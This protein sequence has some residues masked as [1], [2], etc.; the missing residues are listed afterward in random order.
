MSKPVKYFMIAAACIGIVIIAGVVAV[1]MLVDIERY[2]PKIEQLVTEKTGYPLTLGGE[3]SLSIFPWVGLSFTELQLDNP[4]G[5]VDKK[6]VRIDSFQARLKVL[7]LL[8]RNVE[9]SSFVVKQP[10]IFLEKNA[11]GIWNWQKLS[12]STKTP[13]ATP[14]AA[15]PASAP[16]PVAGESGKQPA[17]K[18]L[19]QDGFVLQ[20]LVVGEFAITDGRIH[21]N[22]LQN[23]VKHEV[24]DFNLQL[25]DVSL[26]TPIKITMSSHLD[27]KPL[28]LKGWAGPVGSDPGVGRL[29]LDLVVEAL[30]TMTVETSGYVDDL[31]G[32]KKYNLDVN[33]PTFSLKKLYSVLDMPFPVATAD[34]KVLDEISLQTTVAGDA[35][36]VALSGAKII[37][38]DSTITLD[39]TAKDFSRPDLAMNLVVDAID[40]DR[41]LPP[42]AAESKPS[43]GQEQSGTPPKP[44]VQPTAA[45][46]SPAKKPPVN[47]EPL[48]KMV[49]QATA[50]LGKVQVHG[51]TVNNLTVDL[52]G[53]NGLFTLNSLLMELYEGSIS[54]TGKVNVQKN[55]PVTALNLTVQ[56][57]QAGPLLKD[58]AEKEIIEGKLKAKVAVTLQGDT[59]PR[60]KES[61]NGKGDLLFLD[62]ALLGL[63]LAQ[64]ARTI[65]SGFTLQQQGEKPK[66]DFAELHAPFTITNG[67][68]NTQETILRSPF[69]RVSAT[70]NADL[71]SESLDMKVK[72]TL[73]G[74]IKGQGDVEERQGVTVPILV[75]GTFKAPKFRPD[76]EA[77]ARDRLPSEEELGEIIKTGKVPA[78]TKEKLKEDVEQAKG[79][80]KGLFG[81]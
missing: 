21:V 24:S 74:T 65:K 61:L 66:T 34:P 43:S 47:Y 60:I 9:I 51:G 5:F 3:I 35:G 18:S 64:M 57:V 40:V 37:L 26:D 7:P 15:A 22:D 6:F 12:E 76:L 81:K 78:E 63:D 2:K 80:L 42:A 45:V 28:S 52:A 44:P 8:S 54:A 36:Q 30:E 59:A 75:G 17:E 69:I 72:P 58:F 73:V 13:P 38:D 62:G 23:K 41:Y 77:L 33:V 71:V 56:N 32:Q 14:P 19:Q 27:G 10:E 20:S 46:S 70:G 48:R 11:N 55:I 50:K 16:L 68:V 25:D 39:L 29:E 53:K 79:L 4:D 1:S 49:L 67:L 31:K